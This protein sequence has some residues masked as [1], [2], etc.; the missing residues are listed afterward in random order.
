VN[1]RVISEAY[2]ND[3]AKSDFG[4]ITVPADSLFVMGDNRNNS[5]DSR[6]WG[7]LPIT[8]VTGKAL[9]CYWPLGHFG[10]LKS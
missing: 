9:F 3:P 8:N 4:P 1:D 5:A 7:F 10:A 6:V 2:V